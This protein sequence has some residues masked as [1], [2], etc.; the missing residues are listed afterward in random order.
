MGNNRFKLYK[1]KDYCEDS[2]TFLLIKS[3]VILSWDE[4]HKKESNQL[5]RVR[6]NIITPEITIEQLLMYSCGNNSLKRNQFTSFFK[7]AIRMAFPEFRFALDSFNAEGFNLTNKTTL[8]QLYN[9]LK[10]YD[11][12]SRLDI[13]DERKLHENYKREYV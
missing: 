9:V 1:P 13:E 4:I 10:T 8:L 5:R 3:A 6:Y 11:I 7:R 12:N 2:N